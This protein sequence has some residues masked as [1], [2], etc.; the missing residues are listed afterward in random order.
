M[1]SPARTQNRLLDE[2][3]DDELVVED[4]SIIYDMVAAA[5]IRSRKTC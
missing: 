2:V 3:V 5:A 1:C 4:E